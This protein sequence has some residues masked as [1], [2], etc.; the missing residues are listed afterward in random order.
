[1]ARATT[2]TRSIKTLF[3]W[4]PINFRDLHHD[5]DRGQIVSM[6]PYYC[7][8]LIL[9]S[10]VAPKRRNGEAPSEPARG[11]EVLFFNSIIYSQ[12]LYYRGDSYNRATRIHFRGW[13]PILIV[14]RAISGLLHW[15]TRFAHPN[16]YI[17]ECS[18]ECS[19]NRKLDTLKQ[20]KSKIKPNRKLHYIPLIQYRQ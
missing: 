16:G 10:T 19:Q 14:A 20:T 17:F 18:Q 5:K 7:K 4:L 8:L 9:Y 1:M 6:N 3:R 12:Q 13:R 11:E 2:M 15:R